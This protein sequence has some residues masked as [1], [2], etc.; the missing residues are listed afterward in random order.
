MHLREDDPPNETERYRG[1]SKRH[2]KLLGP[3]C[4]RILNPLLLQHSLSGSSSV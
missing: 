3:V 2:Q 4:E 1:R